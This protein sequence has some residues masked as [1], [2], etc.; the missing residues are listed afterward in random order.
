M[1][2]PFC[3]AENA[4]GE[5]FC[6]ECGRPLVKQEKKKKAVGCG[7]YRIDGTTFY[8]LAQNSVEIIDTLKDVVIFPSAQQYVDGKYDL[9]FYNLQ[10]NTLLDYIKQNP[11]LHESAIRFLVRRIIYILDRIQ[12]SELLL[13]SCDLDDFILIDNDPEKIALR[14]VRP[15]FSLKNAHFSENYECGE[16]AA[17]EIRNGDVS[18]IKKSTDVY[19][20]AQL[21]N[22]IL[23][24][25][26]YTAGDIDSQLFWAYNFTNPAFGSNYRK[27]HHWMGSCLSMFTEKRFRDMEACQNAF[28]ICCSMDEPSVLNPLHIDDALE[29]NVGTGKKAIMQS[30]GRVKSEWNEDVIEKWEDIEKGFS[31]YL[32]A[33]GISNCD[34]GSG[35]VASNIIRTSFIQVLEDNIDENFEKLTYDLVEQMAYQIVEKSNSAIWDKSLNYSGSNGIIMGSTFIFLIIYEGDLYYYSLGDSPLYLIRD[36]NMIPLNSPDNVGFLALLKGKSYTEYKK[37]EGK[38]NL[39]LYVGGEYARNKSQYYTERSVETIAL[40]AGDI[41]LASSDGVVDYYGNKISDT[42]WEK[43]DALS[44]KLI[45]REKTLKQRAQ[46]IIKRDNRNGGGDNLS[47]ILIEVEG[48]KENE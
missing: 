38:D 13:G 28:E 26:R 48:D 2:C 4:E 45:D 46:A 21:F 7:K 9:L 42:K 47:V 16:F 41:V 5:I 20:V 37:M 33:D 40:K 19:L 10:G 32:I 14:A 11:Q 39:A 3:S 12:K 44:Q 1:V 15:L 17:P 43:E 31:A 22:R 29:T 25:D 24:G 23:I 27:Y 18:R 36:G 30:I 8:Y 34:I 35:Y 6:S